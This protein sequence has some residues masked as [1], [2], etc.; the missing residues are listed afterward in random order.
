MDSFVRTL[1]L[2]VLVFVALAGINMIG[3]MATPIIKR[4]VPALG[5]VFDFV[6]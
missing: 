1:L 6:F 2:I 5:G 4:Y 3:R